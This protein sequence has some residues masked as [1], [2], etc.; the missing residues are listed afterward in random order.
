MLLV[1]DLNVP[2]G[3]VFVPDISPKKGGYKISFAVLSVQLSSCCE[4]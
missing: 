3:C 1:F 4:L 2:L